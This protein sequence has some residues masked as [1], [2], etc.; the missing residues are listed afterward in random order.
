M[1][2]LNKDI[3]THCENLARE[4][5]KE[6]G[7]DIIEY[8]FRNYLGE[9]DIICIK[10]NLLIIFEVKGRYSYDYGLPKES[11]TYLKQKSIQKVTTSYMY[12]KKLA[13]INVRFDVLEVYL[14]SNN[15]S[16]I[17]N[18]IKDAFR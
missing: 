11:I 13:N 12:Y 17:I 14:N 6:H 18:H 10:N 7:Y 1:K 16:F 15:A 5:L 3:G 9:I 2:K 4:Y 8:N